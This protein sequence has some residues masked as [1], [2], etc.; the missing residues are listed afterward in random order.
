LHVKHFK[1][2]MEEEEEGAFA[3]KALQGFHGRRRRRS[4]CM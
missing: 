4:L 1:D 3:C 2:F